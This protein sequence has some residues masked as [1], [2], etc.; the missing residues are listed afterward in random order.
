MDTSLP[1]VGNKI[2]ARCP[3]CRKN[4]W[5]I[6][7]TVGQKKPDI[8]VCEKCQNQHKYRLP[9]PPKKATSRRVAD[10]QEAARK[11]W[12]DLRPNMNLSSATGYSMDARYRRGTLIKHPVFGLGLV[13]RSVGPRK[14]SVLFEDGRKIMRCQ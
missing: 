4:N 6:I 8:V 9:I 13:E 2:E 14:I 3:K 11:E 5:H 10:P 1:P 12:A 7:L